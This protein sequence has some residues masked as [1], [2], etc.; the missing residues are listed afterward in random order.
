VGATPAATEQSTELTPSMT[1]RGVVLGTPAYMSPEQAR[2]K[3]LDRRTDVWS[4]GCVLYELLTGR[5]AFPGETS[6]DAIAAVLDREPDWQA[7]PSSSP[8]P[9][10]DLIGRCLRKDRGRR[11]Q[12]MGDARIVIDDAL[13]REP[14][15]P[16]GPVRA[17]VPW[18][19]TVAGAMVVAAIAGGA[20]YALNRGRASD[21]TT[22]TVGNAARLTHDSGLSEW[23]TWSPDGATL[24]FASN[25]GGDFEVYVRRADGGQEV[26][27]SSD[28]GEDMQPAFSPDGA[29]LAFVSTRSSRGGTTKI[30][31][32]FSFDFRTYGGDIWVVPALGGRPRRLADGGNFPAWRPDGAAV[33]FVSGPESHRSILEV[34]IQGG[35][36]R[37]L[38]PTEA[39][40]WEIVRLQFSPRG[41]WL[42]FETSDDRILIMDAAG[43]APRELV[44][45][46]SHAWDSGGGRVFHVTRDR[47][48][49]TRLW[50]LDVDQTT[51][52]AGTAPH[53]VAV[54]T[55]IL[56]DTAIS[57]DGSR[58]AVS[59]QD[60]SLNLTRLPLTPAG[61]GP[62]GVEE[63]LSPGNV[64]DHYP[65]FAPDGKRL[66][67]S[68]NRLGALEIW[69][70][71]LATRRQERIT[72]P[73]DDAGATYPTWLPSGREL[74]VTRLYADGSR[75]LWRVAVDGSGA[76]E[77][78]SRKAGLIGSGLA[79]D[80]RSILLSYTVDGTR[81]LFRFDIDTRQESQLTSSPGDKYE[82]AFSRDGQWIT[83][84][85]NAGGSVQ[86][87]RMPAAGG[88]AEPLTT[89]E[90]RIRH[91]GYSA[92][93]QWIY[94]QPSH[95]N[96]FRIPAS[97]GQQQP[98]TRFP[99]SGLYIDE[100]TLAPDGRSLIYSRNN[101]GSSLWL[102]T[103]GGRDAGAVEP[104]R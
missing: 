3:P 102:L 10:R 60:G 51:G 62:A 92:D 39:S 81:Q 25:R 14:G 47:A 104:A 57:R 61:D 91:F 28:P 78:R 30:A 80:G 94:L 101:G 35:T 37:A 59:E 100:P 8:P 88:P 32:T 19:G 103:L 23:P 22:V 89:G 12:H 67:Y 85:F 99:E 24:A 97:G 55:G 72:L 70:F 21:E 33:A 18:P 9:V 53:T 50:T 43:G 65:A 93:G 87:W 26:N 36:V 15:V 73:G 17:G 42:T 84:N 90:G 69:I 13:N 68:S 11:L 46:S 34:P 64:I 41:R 20:G 40:S 77:L 66:A 95:Q 58:L 52:A 75:S 56:R 5:Q 76:V 71:D 31:D 98:V 63:P 44:R 74:I 27:I 29:Q 16:V 79:P 82:G 86:L 49:G 45:G 6:S 48:G 38:L 4:F 54:M 83:F 2:A 1:V 7:V 96:V